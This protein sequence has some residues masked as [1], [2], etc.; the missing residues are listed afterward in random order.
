MFDPSRRRFDLVQPT[1]TANVYSSLEIL[2]YDFGIV[3]RQPLRRS[4]ATEYRL[5]RIGI[6]NPKEATAKGREPQSPP[7]IRIYVQHRPWWQSLSFR[8]E[9][10]FAVAITRKPGVKTNPYISEAILRK[11]RS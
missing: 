9:P 1:S 10:E 8:K 5:I 11:R 3:A 7:T 2:G 6:V 4:V